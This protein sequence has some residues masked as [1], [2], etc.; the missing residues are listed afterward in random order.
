MNLDFFEKITDFKFVFL[1]FLHSAFKF[2][3]VKENPKLRTVPNVQANLIESYRIIS[4]KWGQNTNGGKSRYPNR[5]R[6][7]INPI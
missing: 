6:L 5:S 1:V 4:W 2:S 3:S 7:F